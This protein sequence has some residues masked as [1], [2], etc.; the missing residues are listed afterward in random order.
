MATRKKRSKKEAEPP[1]AVVLP[2]GK[3]V[4]LLVHDWPFL[5]SVIGNGDLVVNKRLQPSRPA[6]PQRKR[7][8]EES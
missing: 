8:D 3:P 6:P 1:E 2:A 7:V 5:Y 4:R